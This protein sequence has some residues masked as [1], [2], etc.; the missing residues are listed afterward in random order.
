MNKLM[1][2]NYFKFFYIYFHV[3]LNLFITNDN[4][5]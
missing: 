2:I 1:V 4:K 5:V 3:Q